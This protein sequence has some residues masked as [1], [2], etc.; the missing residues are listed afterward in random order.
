MFEA[1]SEMVWYFIG[2]YIIN[3]T[4]HGRLEIRN[5]SSRV[6][7]YATINYKLT[8]LPTYEGYCTGS[9]AIPQVIDG[10]HSAKISILT[11]IAGAPIIGCKRDEAARA[12][13]ELRE[14]K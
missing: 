11:S 6:R 1:K 14:E 13:E 7:Q 5:F 12:S 8:E 10:P 3:R 2:V 9:V 4:L